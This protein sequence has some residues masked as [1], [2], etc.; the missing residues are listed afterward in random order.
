MLMDAPA[1]SPERFVVNVLFTSMLLTTDVG[2]IPRSITFLSGLEDGMGKPFRLAVLYLS[3]NPLTKMSL[4]APDFATPLIFATP[5]ATSDDPVLDNSLA[6]IDSCK[7]N[8][9]S[10]NN[11]NF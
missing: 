1:K 10:S 6:P 9:S 5:S 3:P 8:Y 2:K 11:Y 7:L 4:L